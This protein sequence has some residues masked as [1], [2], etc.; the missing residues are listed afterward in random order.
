MIAGDAVEH[1]EDEEPYAANDE[2]SIKHEILQTDQ[3]RTL[4]MVKTE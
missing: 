4:K 1:S 2:N 3:M